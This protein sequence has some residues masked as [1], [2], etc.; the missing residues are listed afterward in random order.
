MRDLLID[1]DYEVPEFRTWVL[2]IRLLVQRDP[3]RN[4]GHESE[5]RKQIIFRDLLGVE[6]HDAGAKDGWG[7][8][9]D[10]AWLSAYIRIAGHVLCSYWETYS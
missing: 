10:A 7:E 6:D 9:A 2:W 4:S 5:L 3:L 1:H 8:E